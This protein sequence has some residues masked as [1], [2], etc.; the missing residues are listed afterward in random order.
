MRCAGDGRDFLQVLR[1]KDF[2]SRHAFV[3]KQIFM[4]VVECVG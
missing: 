4:T 2:F 3:A 1:E